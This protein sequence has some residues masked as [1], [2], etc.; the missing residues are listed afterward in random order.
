[1]KLS[2]VVPTLNSGHHLETTLEK[3]VSVVEKYE[4]ESEI[5]V[6]DDGSTDNT[7]VVLNR[8]TTANSSS[9]VLRAVQLKAN[10]GQHSATLCG[11]R[12]A[13]GRIVVTIDDDLQNDPSEILQL[14]SELD[15]AKSQAVIV[16]YSDQQKSLVRKLGSRLIDQ[17]V[18]FVFGKPHHLKL[19]PF[20]A[21]TRPLVDQICLT[22]N[23]E[24]FITGE[25]LRAADSVRNVPGQHSARIAARSRYRLSPILALARRIMFSYSTK[26]LT[27]IT[28]LALLLSLAFFAIAGFVLVRSWIR[29]GVLPGWTSEVVIVSS[30]ASLNFLVLVVLAMYI[31][32]ILKRISNEPQY[33][34]SD[35]IES[36]D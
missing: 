13:R 24:P 20:R 1:M 22:S 19:S 3:L 25:V 10:F 2:V 16:A 8:L 17:L 33:K 6:V 5:I 31:G 26:P 36:A 14:I 18:H 35:V 23:P 9:V 29:G 15:A 32:Q 28:Q 7:W 30:F 21:L 12:L 11:L 4:Y 27:M 34:I